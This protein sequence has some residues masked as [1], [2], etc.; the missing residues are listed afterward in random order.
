MNKEAGEGER[1]Q[2]RVARLFSVKVQTTDGLS[3]LREKVAPQTG[4]LDGM[5][6]WK[7]KKE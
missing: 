7:R 6:G 3:C 5:K 2:I 1:T 4:Y